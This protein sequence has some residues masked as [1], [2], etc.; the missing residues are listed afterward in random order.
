MTP[1]QNVFR[2]ISKASAAGLVIL[3]LGTAGKGQEPAPSIELLMA[4][5]RRLYDQVDHAAAVA[6][7]DRAIAQLQPRAADR[8]VQPQ[9]VAALQLRARALFGLSERAR[10]QADMEAL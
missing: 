2:F 6:V 5:A 4:D 9:L 10:S 1:T 8:S 7:L 3:L